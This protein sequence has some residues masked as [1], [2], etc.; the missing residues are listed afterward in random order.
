MEIK[1]YKALCTYCFNRILEFDSLSELDMTIP[2]NEDFVVEC[3]KC[4]K[5][6]IVNIEY[7]IKITPRYRRYA[8]P[9]QTFE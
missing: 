7:E 6:T 5:R 8:P 9:D 2:F 1:E 3:K 4:N